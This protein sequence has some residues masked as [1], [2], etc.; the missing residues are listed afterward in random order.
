[1]SNPER[2]SKELEKYKNISAKEVEVMDTMLNETN[3]YANK[4]FSINDFIK[5][6]PITMTKKKLRNNI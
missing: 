4:D 6:E 3:D 1:M 5:E 2:P